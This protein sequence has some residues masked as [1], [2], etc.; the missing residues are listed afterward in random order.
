MGR[1]GGPGRSKWDCEGY[2]QQ[3]RDFVKGVKHG[4]VEWGYRNPLH[5]DDITKGIIV[6]DV[7]WLLSYLGRITDEQLR[8][9]LEAS[10]AKPKEIECFA[11][12]IRRRIDQ[13]DAVV[14]KAYA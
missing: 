2:A 4:E 8:A 1:W 3:T 6:E 9:G 12:A 7:A 14:R 11:K 5:S 10:G 13:L